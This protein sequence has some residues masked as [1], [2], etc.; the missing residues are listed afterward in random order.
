MVGRAVDH[1]GAVAGI[2]DMN[3]AGKSVTLILFSVILSAIAQLC[4]KAG[5]VYLSIIYTDVGGF[6]PEIEHNL[7]VLIWVIT[8]LGCYAMS[9]L[10]WMA[11]IAKLELSFAYPMLSLS[12]VLVYIA[13]ANWPLLHEQASL[14]RSLGI[15][16][17]VAGVTLIARSG[18]SAS[19]PSCR[20]GNANVETDK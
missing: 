9:L 1:T 11:A 16:I 18:E 13:A 12:Y 6:I 19:N 15:I 2:A 14:Q 3:I 10:C 17:I 20:S 4:M 8:G 7:P 5:M